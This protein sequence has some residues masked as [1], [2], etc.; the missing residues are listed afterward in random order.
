MAA[1]IRLGNERSGKRWQHR[2]WRVALFITARLHRDPSKT[3]VSTNTNDYLTLILM[4]FAQ[5]QCIRDRYIVSRQLGGGG[6]GVVYEALDRS[7]GRQ[8]ALKTMRAPAGDA[9]LRFKREFRLLQ[10]IHHP[11]LVA[12]GE[13][14]EDAGEWCFSME[15]VHGT[16]FLEHVRVVAAPRGDLGE[17]VGPTEPKLVI[18]P[19]MPDALA[20]TIRPSQVEDPAVGSASQAKPQP[21]VVSVQALDESRLR[22]AM[23]QLVEGLHVLHRAHKV[24][25]DIKP[26]NVLV[27][28]SGRVVILD[29]GL[30]GEESAP[31]SAV[32]GTV[33]YM[34]PE[35]AAGQQTGVAAD[36]YSVGVLLYEALTGCLPYTGSALEILADKQ[37]RV[38]RPPSEIV[39]KVAPDLESL[40]MDLL[41]IEPKNR[42]SYAEIIVRLRSKP[43]EAR[44]GDSSGIFFVGRDA[45]LSALMGVFLDAQAAQGRTFLLHGESGVG[46]SALMRCFAARAT[47]HSPRLLV[48]Q[49]RCYEH[50]AVPFKAVD[51]LIDN[52]ARIVRKWP[53]ASAA[54]LLPRRIAELLQ[55]FPVLRLVPAFAE[56]PAAT[57]ALALDPHE[58]QLRVFAALRELLARLAEHQPL[59]LLIDD[60]QWT[61]ADSLTLLS[62][63]MSPPDEPALMLVATVRPSAVALRGTWLDRERSEPS[64]QHLVVS[65]LPSSDAI[66][67][68]ERLAT[69]TGEID[70]NRLQHLVHEAGGHPL[71]LQE[72][73]RHAAAHADG[74]PPRLEETLWNRISALPPPVKHILTLAAIMGSPLRLDIAIRASELDPDTVERAVTQLRSMNLLRASLYAQ[75]QDNVVGERRA[76][77]PY[78]DRVRELVSGKLA[79]LVR[80]SCHRRLAEAIAVAPNADPELLCYHFAGAGQVP[81][82]GEYALQAGD[83]AAATL[84]FERAARFYKQAVDWLVLDSERK[85]VLL[86][87]LAQAHAHA[88]RGPLAAQAYLDAAKLG[89][90]RLARRLRVDAA[91]QLLRSGHQQDGQAIL[92][93]V[94][95]EL[96]IDASVHQTMMIASLIVNRARQALRAP[97]RVQPPDR[98]DDEALER[99]DAC[100]V[101]AYGYNPVNRLRSIYFQW[102]CFEYALK[103]GEPEMLVNALS[104]IS[105]SY[106]WGGRSK[107]R[108]ICKSLLN[109]AR[110]MAGKANTPYSYAIVELFTALVELLCGNFLLA[111]SLLTK[112]EVV[113]LDKCQ[114]THYEINLIRIQRMINDQMSGNFKESLDMIP[115]YL[116][117]AVMRNDIFLI[118]QIC[119]E[120][121]P[122]SLL[123]E[124]K[125]DRSLQVLREAETRQKQISTHGDLGIVH[126]TR[127]RSN[128]F[129]YMGKQTEAYQQIQREFS[130]SS[131]FFLRSSLIHRCLE[132]ETKARCALATALLAS[133]ATR[134]RLLKEASEQIALCEKETDPWIRSLGMLLRAG[135]MAAQGKRAEAIAGYLQAQQSLEAAELVLQAAAARYRYGQLQG[136]IKGRNDQEAARRFLVER[137]IKEPDRWIA[138]LS[139]ANDPE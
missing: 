10:D 7:T 35:Q 12:L 16:N 45:E 99:A 127:M 44:E 9:L 56:A 66:V 52:L 81:Q 40:C 133:G 100:R 68:A 111:H 29:F 69:L 123:V 104:T 106:A 62:R 119:I 57:A 113:L 91:S 116:E 3:R 2:V 79:A 38:A 76:V 23:T 139:P 4:G 42:P 107:D 84:A 37:R 82:A 96:G 129:L 121:W 108:A 112:A 36:W 28:N 41:R 60:L 117:D 6:M 32:L 50:E 71:F 53:R 105:M 13:L 21:A 97:V 128:V 65:E 25:R 59:L 70:R 87:K 19:T 124:G 39:S 110:A 51:G 125:P 75:E 78:H 93:G 14:M 126:L 90:G 122:R 109:E 43:A 63:I 61:D 64:V 102:L 80:Q 98:R 34:A 48:L 30:I 55:A 136:P 8:V 46:K 5:G 15:L 95:R 67:L 131:Q 85:R 134:E 94:L 101:A 73:V 18:D 33:A 92:D 120:V 74:D 130:R 83:K 86:C 72:L 115:R 103:A 47:E 11:N 24:H 1:V 27:T 114:G 58:Q 138:M 17:S 137:R 31:E 88:G 22:A 89:S 132:A 135:I 118:S 26:D 54:A 77:E 20:Q 49:G